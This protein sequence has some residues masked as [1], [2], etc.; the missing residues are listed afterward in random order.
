MEPLRLTYDRLV[1]QIRGVLRVAKS[2]ISL[3]GGSGRSA[4]PTKY[5]YLAT[6]PFVLFFEEFEGG[7]RT[8]MSVTARVG[9]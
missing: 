8:M 5:R 2:Q 3:A 1:R 4:Q 9:A 6:E 7:W